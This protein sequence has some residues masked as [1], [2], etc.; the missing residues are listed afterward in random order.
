MDPVRHRRHHRHR[1]AAA[2]PGQREPGRRRARRRLQG[3]PDHRYGTSSDTAAI[4]TAA[5]GQAPA[6][7]DLYDLATGRPVA[8]G[9]VA[10]PA[11]Q[12]YYGTYGRTVLTF[13]GSGSTVTGWYLN[14]LDGG[15]TVRTKVALPADAVLATSVHDGDQNSLILRHRLDN[16]SHSVLVDVVTG[17]TTPLP[18]E[19]EFEFSHTFRLAKGAVLRTGDQNMV[20]VLDRAQPQ[21][22]LSSTYFNPMGGELRLLGNW[23]LSTEP[24]AG[25]SGDNRGRPLSFAPLGST[26][27]IIE[28]LLEFADSQLLPAP[29]GS[30][31]AVG[32]PKAP[33]YGTQPETAVHRITAD[34][35][36]KPLSARLA[37]VPRHPPPSSA[38]R[39]VVACSPPPPTP[40]SSSR[41]TSPARTAATGSRTTRPR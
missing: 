1:S 25:T 16:L 35:T 39:S 15:S 3:N 34:G 40:S 26:S 27:G 8:L 18:D 37:A 38:C 29:D 24:T 6:K 23:L 20:D 41:A 22:V 17:Q 14:R 12:T 2:R 5:T 9:T 30:L 13:E 36:A 21:T 33:A 10:I 28:Y 19:G 4:H 32:S 7:V 31:I 11:G